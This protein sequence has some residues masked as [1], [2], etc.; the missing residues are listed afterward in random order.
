MSC[1]HAHMGC[2]EMHKYAHRKEH[3]NRCGYRLCRCPVADCLHSGAQ[4][5]LARH[6]VDR[7]RSVVQILQR[8]PAGRSV[9][10]T[11]KATDLFVMV[12]GDHGDDFLVH[13]EDRKL[14]GDVFF[15]TAL[16][17]LRNSYYLTVQV[18]S[19][20]FAMETLAHDIQREV[21][22]KHDF[23]LVPRKPN[24]LIPRQFH[25][26]LWLTDQEIADDASLKN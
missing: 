23:L 26:E 6:I 21:D 9:V 17:A 14:L 2:E 4:Q 13:H 15:C 10:F 3:E 19:K 20:F 8:A 25:V 5:D 11:M 1:K 7:H 18:D 12:E 24:S 22:W 16:S